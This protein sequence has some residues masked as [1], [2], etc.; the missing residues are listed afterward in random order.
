MP[1]LP[2][3]L[4]KPELP[5]G[6]PDR[7]RVA[8]AFDVLLPWRWWA[9]PAA[10]V[11]G[12]VLGSIGNIIASIVGAAAG[13]SISHPTPAVNIADDI[14]FDLGFVAAAIYI[15]S[16]LGRVRPSEFGFRRASLRR[17]LWMLPLAAV[18]YFVATAVYASALG[19]NGREQLPTGLGSTSDTAAMI[20]VGVFV[21]VVAPICEE[22][23]FRGFI[24]GM[25]RS[26]L[27]PRWW[28]P[29]AAATVTG[30]LFGGAH[31]G[32]A[33]AKYLVPLAFL[34]F[35]LCILR[36]R[37]GSL[38]PGM[39]LHSLNNSLAFGIDE[40]HWGAGKLL[41]MALLALAAIAAIAGPLGWREPAVTVEGAD[42]GGGSPPQAAARS[43][44]PPG[45]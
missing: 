25:L 40:L 20:G 5:E 36:W 30:V 44:G 1:S 3:P 12:V 42:H 26:W 18:T 14:L 31:A 32:S 38:Y 43:I 4:T 29:W 17:V 19:L 2:P 16:L 45:V 21:T 41:V 11:L 6:A 28:G 8:A 22:F 10:I 9:V 34:G 23:F 24:F 13:S 33:A 15:A 39:A 35:V 27:A 37:T 7:G